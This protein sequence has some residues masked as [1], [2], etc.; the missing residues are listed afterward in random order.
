MIPNE[1]RSSSLAKKGAARLV[2]ARAQAETFNRPQLNLA[3]GRP[4]NLQLDALKA[5][6]WPQFTS[7]P[8]R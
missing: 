6:N 8:P 7:E 5:F 2:P 1:E 4:T 3:N